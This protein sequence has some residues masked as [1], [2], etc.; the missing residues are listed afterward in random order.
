M[1][2]VKP[3]DKITFQD[4]VMNYQGYSTGKEYYTGTVKSI[5]NSH[6][7]SVIFTQM[8]FNGKDWFDTGNVYTT[9][10]VNDILAVNA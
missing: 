7:I 2:N 4:D 5:L 3:G 9:T 8:S 10:N 1:M 6:I